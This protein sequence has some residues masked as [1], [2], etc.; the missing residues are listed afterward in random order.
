RATASTPSAI[1]SSRAWK[2][3]GRRRPRPGSISNS[4][5]VALAGETTSMA[6]TS[7]RY[8][9]LLLARCLLALCLLSG[10]SACSPR[11]EPDGQPPAAQSPAESQPAEQSAAAEASAGELTGEYWDVV[12]IGDTRVGHGRTTTERSADGSLTTTAEHH[13]QM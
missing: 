4:S 6:A 8:R 3:L 12:F 5:L 10:V 11:A 1:W 13:M 7:K 2:G 9:A